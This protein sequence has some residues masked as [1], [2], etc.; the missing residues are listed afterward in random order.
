M[1]YRIVD[2]TNIGE[3]VLLVQLLQRECFRCRAVELYSFV[4]FR[5]DIVRREWIS[6][7]WG[8]ILKLKVC[9]K[10]TELRRCLVELIVDLQ[11]Q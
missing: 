9:C 2:V 8:A 5:W 10:L 7:G 1:P 6:V 3:V 11:V 4:E